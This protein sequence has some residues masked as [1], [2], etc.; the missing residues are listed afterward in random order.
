VNGLFFVYPMTFDTGAWYAGSTLLGL[1]AAAAI[2]LYGFRTALGGR[3][4]FGG[5]GLPDS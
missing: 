1:S 3:P 2:I 5:A 4:A